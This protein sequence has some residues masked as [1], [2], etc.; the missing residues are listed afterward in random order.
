MFEVRKPISSNKTVRMPD[1]LIERLEKIAAKN[2]ISFNQLVV[3]CC[4]YALDNMS[5]DKKE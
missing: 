4:E 2:D 1:T 3:Q 5:E